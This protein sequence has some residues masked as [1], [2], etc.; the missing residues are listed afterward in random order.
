MALDRSL[1]VMET[2]KTAVAIAR[3]IGYPVMLKSTA[4]G[5]GIGMLALGH[6]SARWP[7]HPMMCGFFVLGGWLLGAYRL[8]RF[9]STAQPAVRA[10]LQIKDTTGLAPALAARGA[11]AARTAPASATGPARDPLERL[12][13]P[14]QRRRQ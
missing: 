11:V 3:E 13:Q 2:A 12:H 1:G 4:G 6:L 14:A 7:M 8:N 10:A 9:R 5:G